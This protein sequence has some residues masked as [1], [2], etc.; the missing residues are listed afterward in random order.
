MEY[1]IEIYFKLYT[2][3]YIGL[4]ALMTT[5]ILGGI[6]L[7]FVM[8]DNGKTGSLDF[9]REYMRVRAEEFA[10]LISLWKKGMTVLVLVLMIAL[11]APSKDVVN[12]WVHPV[13]SSQ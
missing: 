13:S 8:A 6:G 11:F 1:L 12:N 9:S 7:L 10:T 3:G 5:V 2:Y 4:L